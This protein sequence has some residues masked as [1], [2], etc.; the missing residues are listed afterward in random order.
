LVTTLWVRELFKPD[1]P[2]RREEQAWISEQLD[3]LTGQFGDH[4]LHGQIVLPTDDFFP[5]VYRGCVANVQRVVDIVRTRMGVE[6]GSYVVELADTDGELELPGYRRTAGA[7]GEYRRDG[8]Q[9]VISISMRQAAA[10]TALVATIAHE[11]GHH[12]LMGEGRVRGDRA[13]VWQRH[14]DTNPRAFLRKGLRYLAS[15]GRG[16]APAGS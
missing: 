3:W 10:P 5:G 6:A 7:A 1:C 12:R 14:L 9:G 8:H 13:A 2:V 15:S 16:T 11:F 4:A